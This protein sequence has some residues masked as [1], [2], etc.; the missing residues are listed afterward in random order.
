MS[1]DLDGALADPSYQIYFDGVTT[2]ARANIATHGDAEG[3]M[4][5]RCGEA[6]HFYTDWQRLPESASGLMFPTSRHKRRHA[7]PVAR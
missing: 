5:S 6:G 2:A 7:K 3:A 4:E 1:T